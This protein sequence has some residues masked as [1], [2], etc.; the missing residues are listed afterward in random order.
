MEETNIYP[1][2]IIDGTYPDLNNY[3][4]AI[5]LPNVSFGISIVEQWSTGNLYFTIDNSS[6]QVPVRYNTNLLP[7]AFT[8]KNLYYDFNR[9]AFILEELL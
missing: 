1:F 9:Q 7:S 2:R 8:N 6:Y 4:Y 3:R 5:S